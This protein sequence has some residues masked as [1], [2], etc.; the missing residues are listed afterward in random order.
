MISGL[1]IGE[2]S[3][4]CPLLFF[5][6][7]KFSSLPVQVLR[8]VNKPV[9]LLY[10]LGAFQTTAYMWYLT[11]VMSRAG[12]LRAETQFIFALWFSQSPA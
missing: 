9:S 11:R 10:T 12:S 1:E 2:V 8:L 3:G 6:L 7:L 4:T 5:S